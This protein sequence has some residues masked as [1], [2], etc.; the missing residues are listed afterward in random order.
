MYLFSFEVHVFGKFAMCINWAP[1][2]SEALLVYR[3]ASS[4]KCYSNR[5]H[6]GKC[7]IA[8]PEQCGVQRLL[9]VPKY[10]HLGSITASN[11]SQVHDAQ[12]RASTAMSSYAP[13]SVKIFGSEQVSL[14]LKYIFLSSLVMT[15]CTMCNVGIPVPSR[16]VL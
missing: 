3:G 1:G 16:C 11:G 7:S 10:K 4:M 14:W 6:E 2:K 5:V 15:S 12:L 8:L 13:L 9:I